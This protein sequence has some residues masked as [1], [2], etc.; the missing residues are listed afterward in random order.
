LFYSLHLIAIDKEDPLTH[1]EFFN[2]ELRQQF[3]NFKSF[4]L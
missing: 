4:K 2:F 1:L 3:Y